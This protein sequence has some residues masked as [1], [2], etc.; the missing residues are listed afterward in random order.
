[1]KMFC[2]STAR[3]VT[4][5]LAVAALSAPA[6]AQSGGL[7]DLEDGLAAESKEALAASAARVKKW[8]D[9]AD[10]HALKERPD[11]GNAYAQ[12]LFDARI[13]ED[14]LGWPGARGTTQQQLLKNSA[15]T[16]AENNRLGTAGG[17]EI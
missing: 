14:L 15:L 2:I 11:A 6:L 10:V 12:G 5:I 7:D 8:F 3:P 4:L 13:R 16:L 17:G 1:M 9:D